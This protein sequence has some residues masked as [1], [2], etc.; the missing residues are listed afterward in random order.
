MLHFEI[1]LFEINVSWSVFCWAE[2]D[3]TIGD[4]VDIPLP[5]EPSTNDFDEE[6]SEEVEEEIKSEEKEEERKKKQSQGAPEVSDAETSGSEAVMISPR[7]SRSKPAVR[8][9]ELGHFI[10]H[11][12]KIKH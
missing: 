2:L 9:S 3:S 11:N 6:D 7:H 12:N 1:D 10:S 8:V 5:A 4:E